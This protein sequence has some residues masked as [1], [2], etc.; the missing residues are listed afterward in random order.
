MQL[1][2]LDL[3]NPG[4]QATPINPDFTKDWTRA[5]LKLS[6]TQRTVASQSYY[7]QLLQQREA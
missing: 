5:T 4:Y 6:Q 2:C 3:K 7:I 1:K